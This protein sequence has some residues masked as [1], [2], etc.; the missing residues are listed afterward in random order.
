MG[1][2]GR[3]DKEAE[4]RK[5]VVDGGECAVAAHDVEEETTVCVAEG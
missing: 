5:G 2:D 4:E 3:R 1:E